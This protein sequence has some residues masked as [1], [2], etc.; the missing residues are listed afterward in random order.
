[1]GADPLATEHRG[2]SSQ[3]NSDRVSAGAGA[4]QAA[5]QTIELTTIHG[6]LPL[7]ER[8]ATGRGHGSGD[9]GHNMVTSLLSQLS[10]C[11]SSGKAK[12]LELNFLNVRGSS[13]KAED[14]G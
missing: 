8:T 14:C 3:Q 5:R 10:E 4:A 9:C 2:G 12:R 7:S 13:G 11:L 1:L 6:S